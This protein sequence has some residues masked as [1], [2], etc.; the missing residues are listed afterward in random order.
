MLN[1][2]TTN[3]H[4]NYQLNTVTNRGSNNNN[5]NRIFLASLNLNSVYLVDFERN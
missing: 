4:C 5:E 1:L 2:V 3:D